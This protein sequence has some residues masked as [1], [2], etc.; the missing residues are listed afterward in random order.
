MNDEKDKIVKLATEQDP[1]TNT[2]ETP[3][4]VETES[5]D[6]GD[7]EGL[8]FNTE[9]KPGEIADSSISDEM[10]TRYIDYSMS[11]IVS[12]AL[13]EV[14][15]G[16]KPSQRR[17]LVAMN[18]MNLIPSAHYRKSAKIA[19]D[20]SGN[21]HPHGE[22]VIYPT[23]VKMAQDFSTRYPLVD[24]QGN[25]GSVDG[26]PAAAMRYTEAKMSKITVELLRDLEKGTVPFIPNY[27]G[28][29]LEPT[30]LPAAIPQLL[31]NG[32]DGI[33][34]GMA[35]KIPPH[36]LTELITA[37]REMIKRG[38]KW[39]GK[40]IYNELRLDREKGER[41]PMTLDPR[42]VDYLGNYIN[43]Y[44]LEYEKQRE[45]IALRI[46]TDERLYPEF[47]SEITPEELINIIPGP[48]FPT[49]GTI[50]DR[51]EILNAYS[52]GRGRILQRAKA[53]I[54]E[55]KKGRYEIIVTEIPFQVNKAY[56]TEKIADLVKEK[57]VEGIADIRDESNREGMRVVIILK[58]DVQPKT[59][60][61]KLYKFTEMQKV[62]NANMIALVEQE[63]KT[64]PLKQMLELFLS[65]RIS[66]VIRRF[67]FDLAE[68][69]YRGHILEGLLKALDI[70]DDIIATIRGSKTQEEA[71]TNLISK[72]DFTEVQAQ[73]ILEMQLRKLAALEREK[74]QDEYKELGE[75]IKEYTLTLADPIKIL[76][77]IDAELSEIVEKHGDARRSK[78][79]KGKIDE[80]SEEDMVAAENTLV[81]LSH[82]GYI[83]RIPPDTYRTQN[84]GGKGITGATTKEDDWISHAILCNTHDDLMFFS[85]RGRVFRIR[86][87][88][89]PEYGRTAKGLPIVNLISLEQGELITSVLNISR[90]SDESGVTYKFLFMA[91][92][93]GT[94]KKTDIKDFE[95]IRA[96]GLI[97]AKL[98]GSDELLKVIPTSG[99][100]EIIMVTREGK[101]IRF[102]EE[103]VRPTGRATMGVRGI[104]FAKDNDE[105]I[106]MDVMV[107]E[108]G[109]FFTLSEKGFGKMS[110]LSDYTLQGR[111]GSGIFTFR[112]TDKTGKLVV[113]KIV[114]NKDESEIVVISEN[115]V[116]IRTEMKNLPILQRQ[117]SGVKIM[118]VATEDKVSAIA[119][120]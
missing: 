17:I 37:L 65:F 57:K 14:K 72:F 109:N 90:N 42:P 92:K 1:E 23:M 4:V 56:L 43:K 76:G 18:D 105:V 94:V 22:V 96:T 80:I 34:V 49:G 27:D 117:T 66:V 59:V 6:G 31:A 77:V 32:S 54:E 30:V 120:I 115:G 50:Y 103:D 7:D 88:E 85:N 25:F 35:T 52:T 87:F 71:K 36:N 69:R 51:N 38:N 99:E 79:I 46:K 40:A 2:P 20:T 114:D 33:A 63:P 68:A 9:F 41:I 91:T 75:K 107:S 97:A 113:A 19:G 55:G 110:K 12:R 45:A 101:S 67:E 3:P 61:N 10:K 16:L 26:D 73:A 89:I 70:L 102:K 8:S 44:S 15:D 98:E 104:K 74:L 58:K 29:R 39:E 116:I 106:S 48:D 86:A 24:G 108:E 13:P 21:Y 53:S 47:K 93:K 62:F 64:L 112:V 81:T 11:V 100:S 118:N 82:S 111:G 83:K 78:V 84:R 5:E 60:L 95:K 28:T 119:V